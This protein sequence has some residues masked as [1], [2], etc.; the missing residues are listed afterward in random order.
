MFYNCYYSHIHFHM[1]SFAHNSY[2]ERHFSLD[3][4]SPNLAPKFHNNKHEIANMHFTP[5]SRYDS[6]AQHLTKLPLLYFLSPPF[7]CFI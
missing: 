2:S 7:N 6:F 1:N 4:V 5:F 3:I